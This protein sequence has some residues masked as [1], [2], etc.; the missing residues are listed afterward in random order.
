MPSVQQSQAVVE[1]NALNQRLVQDQAFPSKVYPVNANWASQLGH[2][3]ERYLYHNRKDWENRKPKDW[4]G[5]GIRGNL[6]ADWW[7]RHMS[8]KG[9]QVTEAERPLSQALRERYQ[10]SGKIDGRIGLNGV[11]RPRL[12]EFKTMN[13]HEYKR[14]NTYDDIV[15]NSKDYIR[16]YVAQI[17]MYLYDNNEEAGLFVICNASTLEWKTIPVYLD[18]GYCE[19]L[20]QRAER[21][22][23]AVYD[24]RPPARI[25]YGSPC[26][27]CDFAHI[28][29]PDI[30]NEGLDMRDDAHLLQLL[31]KRE[32]LRMAFE[33]YKMVDEEAKEIAK[34]VGRDFLVGAD[35]KCEVKHS[36]VR[37]LDTKL[38]PIEVRTPY[39][40]ETTMTRVEFVP[41]GGQ[42]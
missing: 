37:R 27:R 11:A 13:E 30:R 22:N 14:V 21:V 20:L 31:S 32:Q 41:L 38:I 4:K 28:C 1:V 26:Q 29:L 39:E 42:Q 5:I 2:P 12:Y 40:V 9:Y 3:C 8:E 36:V 19:W 17:Q 23:R 35:F 15:E 6:I 10:I 24:S 34:G 18:Y 33:E 25:A 7:K 16:M